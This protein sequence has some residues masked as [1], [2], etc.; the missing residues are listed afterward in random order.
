VTSV[1][2]MAG[3]LYP[4]SARKRVIVALRAYFDESGTHW[5]GPQASD[6]FVL[7]G[8]L[9]PTELWDNKT[10]SGFKARWDG[11]MHGKPFHATEMET[12]PQGPTVKVELA[13]LVRKSGIIGIRGGISIPAFKRLVVP[14]I[15]QRKEKED[16]YL[17]L[18]AD[19][20]CEA[21]RRADMFLNENKEE[22]IGFVFADHKRWSLIAH[23]MYDHVK[24]DDETPIEVS[25][26]MGAVAFDC[27]DEFVPLQAADHLA[28]ES[29]HYMTDPQGTPAR[30]AMNLLIDWPQV[31][32]TFYGEKALTLY[33]EKCKAEGIL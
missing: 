19:V 15:K 11:V 1:M 5:G 26:K 27:I 10:D 30:P 12:N 23:E 9:A 13:N 20:I 4:P 25:G 3:L 28:F 2:S 7:C 14:H 32:G 16:P 33:V 31:F 18:F 24:A 22:R 29:F 17:F 21:V 6:V 8:Y